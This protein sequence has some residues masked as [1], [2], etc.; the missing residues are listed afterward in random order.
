MC[1]E[2]FPYIK[3]LEGQGIEYL[4]CPIWCGKQEPE[5][6][7]YRTEHC[8]NCPR[9]REK[10]KFLRA[11]EALITE[12]LPE[13][14]AA[15]IDINNLL[16]QLYQ[17]ASAKSLSEHDIPIKA[18]RFIDIYEAERDRYDKLERFKSK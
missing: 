1:R 18:Q 3:R 13:K 10:K 6:D 11:A 12:W 9:P 15:E 7:I 5:I 8:K 16:D 17:T 14:E 2:Y 4:D